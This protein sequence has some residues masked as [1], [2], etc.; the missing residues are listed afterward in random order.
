M[1]I[2]FMTK[3]QLLQLTKQMVF[4][5]QMAQLS[6]NM[7]LKKQDQASKDFF[8]QNFQAFYFDSLER[9]NEFGQ[10]FA[11]GYASC[12]ESYPLESKYIN[13][14]LK[15]NHIN[16]EKLYQTYKIFDH[17]KDF[18]RICQNER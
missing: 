9:K 17:E 11:L 1:K 13:K 10:I 6:Y 3:D 5:G 15:H 2:Q 7:Y 4:L 8:V 14:K 18:K 12:C 16:I